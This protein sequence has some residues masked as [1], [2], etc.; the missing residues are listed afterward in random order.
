MSLVATLEDI[1]RPGPHVGFWH[2]A[3]LNR[4]ARDV[5]LGSQTGRG[6]TRGDGRSCPKRDS[7]L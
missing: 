6:P 2:L 1:T 4:E 3:D 7:G 5:G